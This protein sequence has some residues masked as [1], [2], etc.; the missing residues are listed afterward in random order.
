MVTTAM[1]MDE[2]I[3]VHQL[4]SLVHEAPPAKVRRMMH[5]QEAMMLLMIRDA[6]VPNRVAVGNGE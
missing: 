3:D 2:P 4:K 1:A 6:R 5:S